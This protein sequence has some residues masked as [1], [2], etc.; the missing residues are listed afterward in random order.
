MGWYHG[1]RRCPTR[2]ISRIELC[3]LVPSATMGASNH[4]LA[5]SERGLSYGL[6]G[7]IRMNKSQLSRRFASVV[8]R[9][10]S[11]LQITRLNAGTLGTTDFALEVGLLWFT[12]VM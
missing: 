5:K 1:A 10:S 8:G 6:L 4:G 12:R 9:R 2:Q 7:R 3:Q 11:S